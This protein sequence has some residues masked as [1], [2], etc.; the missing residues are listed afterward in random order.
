MNQTAIARHAFSVI[1][2]PDAALPGGREAVGHMLQEITRSR[3]R[4]RSFFAHLEKNMR[5]GN[6]D[7]LIAVR[8]Q[9]EIEKHLF[10]FACGGE[11]PLHLRKATAAYIE[12][13]S[14][15]MHAMESIRRIGMLRIPRPQPIFRI[16]ARVR[17]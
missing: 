2:N 8:F 3:T 4:R 14:S 9:E 10:A 17:V 12:L 13:F 1:R 16:P 11:I 5:D 7:A 6:P 15:W